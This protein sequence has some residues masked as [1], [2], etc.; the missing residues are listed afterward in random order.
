MSEFTDWMQSNWYALGNLLFQFAFLAAA[1]WFA[2]EM[3]RTIRA[4]QEQ[5]GALLKLSI[6][7]AMTE[8]HSPLLLPSELSQ[9]RVPIG[10]HRRRYLLLARRSPQKTVRVVGR[11][12]GTAW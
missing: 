5:V 12:S 4:S 11:L 8:R 6:T 2:R 1:V 9:A 7:G 10:L 3:L